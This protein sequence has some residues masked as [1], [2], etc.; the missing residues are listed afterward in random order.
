MKKAEQAQN[1][2]ALTQGIERICDLHQI[3]YFPIGGSLR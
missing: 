2:V 3:K 1:L